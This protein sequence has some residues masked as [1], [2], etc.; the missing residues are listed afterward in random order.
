MSRL[1]FLVLMTTLMLTG[2]HRKTQA[3]PPECL[4]AFVCAAGCQS[5]GC[6]Q[7]CVDGASEEAQQLMSALASCAEEHGCTEAGATA[8]VKASCKAELDACMR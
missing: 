1:V 2:C 6:L 5:D 8:C 4:R 3:E 7:A